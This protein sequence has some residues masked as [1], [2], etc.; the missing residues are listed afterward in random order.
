M[1]NNNIT[2]MQLGMN[3]ACF[4]GCINSDT[5]AVR[6]NKVPKVEKCLE[7]YFIGYVTI[8]IGFVVAA[9]NYITSL[10]LDQ[11]NLSVNHIAD[12]DV[13]IHGKS[14]CAK[15]VVTLDG[16]LNYNVV[17]DGFRPYEPVQATG[18][19]P[20]TA[21]TTSSSVPV[22]K[23]LAASFYEYNLPI[24]YTLHAEQGVQFINDCKGRTVYMT[25]NNA[26]FMNIL[27]NPD[28]TRVVNVPYKVTICPY[29]AQGCGDMG[30]NI[31]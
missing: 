5:C 19:F 16:S 12:I 29:V 17:L 1:L 10:T 20:Y 18:V 3:N 27:G 31:N 13:N 6:I 2:D 14:M 26:L 21:F 24:N 9:D 23:L 4:G 30:S 11:S 25:S 22:W 7:L 8:P 28:V 15:D